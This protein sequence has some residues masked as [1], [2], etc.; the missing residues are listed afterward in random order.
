M[1]H[2]K[3]T[4]SSITSL[5]LGIAGLW[6]TACSSGD[7]GTANTAPGTGGTGASGGSSGT[8]ALAGTGGTSGTGTGGA[9][10]SAGVS[11][12]GSAGVSTGGSAG[13]S[14]GGSA[15]VSTGGGA[16]AGAGGSAGVST[17]G[18]SGAGAGG[19]GGTDIGGDG[20]TAGSTGGAGAGGVSGAAG[21]AGG[22]AAG[23]G[24]GGMSGGGGTAG[25]GGGDNLN[26]GP[27]TMGWIGCSMGENVA[28]GYTRAGGTRMWGDYGNG[29]AVVQNWTTNNSSN[30]QGFDRQS[31]M[32]GK[33][34]AIW[35]MICIF[36]TGATMD[37]VRTMVNN[38]KTHAADGAYI[39]ITGQP[40]YTDG[41]VC[42]LA[43][44]GGPELTDMQAQQMAM[45]DPQVHYAGVLGP[46]AQGEYQ[47]DSCHANN[48]GE[49]K[50]GK[51]VLAIWH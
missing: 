9:G 26:S 34:V 22:G 20:G 11:T 23:A 1:K 30:W 33:P 2:R 18:G 13:V 37:E 41:H 15:G 16:G 36:S 45:E 46:L 39:Y 7:D 5:G 42:T 50:L 32:Y 49:D 28:R 3:L 14:T 19:M 43:G 10:G 38:A 51:Q 44:N 29:G 40:L 24:A 8:G 27:N 35:I 21:A 17:G 4:L 12:G 47:S 31:S 25:S 48:A 6:V